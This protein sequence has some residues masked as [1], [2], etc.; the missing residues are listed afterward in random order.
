MATENAVPMVRTNAAVTELILEMT[1]K[2]Y[3]VSAVVNENGELAGIFTDGDLRRLVQSGGELLTLRAVDVMT[4]N[5]KT[6]SPNTMARECLDILEHYRITQ[7]LVCDSNQHPIG[8]VHI[9][10]LLTLGL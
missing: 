4:A 5:P 7:L 2:R 3:G 8:V 1:S 10:D 6:V 9:H